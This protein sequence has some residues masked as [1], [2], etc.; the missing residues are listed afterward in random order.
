[1]RHCLQKKKEKEFHP[2]VNR[3]TDSS[4][5]KKTCPTEPSRYTP[6]EDAAS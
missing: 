4:L 1:M 6:A 3:A 2:I 5:V